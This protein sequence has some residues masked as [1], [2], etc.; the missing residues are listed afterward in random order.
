MWLLCS[1]SL[2]MVV[3]VPS[4]GTGTVVGA[5]M[6]PHLARGPHA[7]L[8]RG[9]SIPRGSGAPVLMLQGSGEAEIV[10][11]GAQ[12]SEGLMTSWGLE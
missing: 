12:G 4:M 10:P 5:H 6:A 7:S 1:H 9:K 3:F 8:G 2:C 11:D